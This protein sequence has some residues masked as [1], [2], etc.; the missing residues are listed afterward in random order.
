M[1][2]LGKYSLLRGGGQMLASKDTFKNEL[3]LFTLL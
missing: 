2:T 3:P 1:Q